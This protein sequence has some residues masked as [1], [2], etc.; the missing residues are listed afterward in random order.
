MR[1]HRNLIALS[2]AGAISAAIAAPASAEP[3]VRVANNGF[4]VELRIG[5][6]AGHR[7]RAQRISP[8]QVRQILRRNGYRGIHRPSFQSRRNVYVV[9]AENR[10]GRDVR[11][12]LNAHSGRILD[13]DRIGRRRG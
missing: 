10:R 8:I 1:L 4:S 7:H 5:D 6:R 13:V 12:T 3:A 9:R 2:I 11:V